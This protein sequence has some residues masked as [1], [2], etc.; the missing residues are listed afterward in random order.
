MTDAPAKA[1]ADLIHKQTLHLAA[2]AREQARKRL[3][4]EAAATRTRADELD[5]AAKAT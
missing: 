2:E 4:A 5:A 1:V 3:A